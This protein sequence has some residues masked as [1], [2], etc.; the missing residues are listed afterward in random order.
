MD[1]TVN[2]KRLWVLFLST[3]AVIALFRFFLIFGVAP[4]R[5]ADMPK[6]LS[7]PQQLQRFSNA[8]LVDISDLDLEN[9]AVDRHG[10]QLQSLG[11]LQ[12]YSACTVTTCWFYIISN[13][14]GGPAIYYKSNIDLDDLYQMSA[15]EAIGFWDSIVFRVSNMRWME[16][17]ASFEVSYSPRLFGVFDLI[18]FILLWSLVIVVFERRGLV[19]A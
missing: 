3:V 16:E 6:M 10:D 5:I 8:P 17:G 14:V 15:G 11:A 7:T 13:P 2:R 9:F 4:A 1:A 19:S 12:R 18:L